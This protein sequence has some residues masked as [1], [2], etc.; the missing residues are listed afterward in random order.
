[1][2]AADEMVADAM[3]GQSLDGRRGVIVVCDPVRSSA[4]DTFFLAMVSRTAGQV[5]NFGAGSVCPVK[6]RIDSV[7]CEMRG[8]FSIGSTPATACLSGSFSKSVSDKICSS[9][10]RDTF[11]RS[12]F[13]MIATST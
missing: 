13:L 1:M 4:R 6:T 3:D 2:G 9:V 11:R 10:C 7:A 8:W 5:V 12:F